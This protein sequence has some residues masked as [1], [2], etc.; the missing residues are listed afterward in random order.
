MKWEGAFVGVT[1]KLFGRLCERRIHGYAL[2]NKENKP[3]MLGECTDG[4]G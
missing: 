3:S 4:K 1:E 2:N